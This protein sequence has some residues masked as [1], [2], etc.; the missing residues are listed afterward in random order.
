MWP[1]TVA[2][3]TEFQV[4]LAELADR[5]APVP[6]ERRDALRVGGVF[7]ASHRSRAWAAAVVL[8]GSRMVESMV[9]PGQL[10]AE[11]VPGLLA[12]RDGPL[13][14]EVIGGLRVAPE[15]LIVDAT[16]RDHP[17]RAGLALHL[18]A[19]LGVA[20][21]GV[22]D[23]PLLA[24]GAQPGPRRGDR[25]PL[26]RE[27][28]LAGYRLRT[29]SGVRSI[30]VHPGWQVDPET[31]CDVVLQVSFAS[32]TPEPLRQARRL[33]REARSAAARTGDSA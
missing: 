31:A 30:V 29:Q 7:V 28:E 26:W 24:S 16:A 9:T 5:Q 3:L 21:I 15:V 17:R 10:R 33:A 12:L 4:R 19:A 32:R 6:L 23:R 2:E 25:A 11:Y 20:T 27:H 13:L 1:A 18:G 8:V 14:A 22:T